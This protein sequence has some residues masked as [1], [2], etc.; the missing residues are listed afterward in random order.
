MGLSAKKFGLAVMIISAIS[1]SFC[2][3]NKTDVGSGANINNSGKDS[4]VITLFG[5][6][7]LS[8]LEL[9]KEKH[10]VEFVKSPMG[11]FVIGIDSVYSGGGYGWLFSVNDS[12]VQVAADAYITKDSDIIAWHYRKF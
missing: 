12:F 10:L 7:N 9:T 3:N 5:Y 8:V 6:D 2:G 4:L 1:L 11:A